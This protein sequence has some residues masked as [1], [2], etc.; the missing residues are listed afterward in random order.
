MMAVDVALDIK[1]GVYYCSQGLWLF[2]PMA[3]TIPALAGLACFAYKRWMWERDYDDDNYYNK[4]LDEAGRPKPGLLTLLRQV[5]Q[6]EFLTTAYQRYQNPELHQ[7]GWLIDQAFNG[8]LEGFPQCLLQT[9]VLLCLEQEA[10]H[11][12]SVDTGIQ[13]VSIAFSCYSMAKALGNISFTLLQIEP[14]LPVPSGLSGWQLLFLQVADVASR[15]LCWCTL[16][17]ALRN[18]SADIHENGQLVLPILMTVEFV[19]VACLLRASLDWT[20]LNASESA[21]IAVLSMT[22]AYLST[23]MLIFV[24]TFTDMLR[25]QAL[26]CCLRGF[27]VLVCLCIVWY[28]VHAV[29]Q[30]HT[31][32]L[33]FT[34][35]S[36]AAYFAVFVTVVFD[37][38]MR[39]QRGR[40]VLPS[41]HGGQFNEAHWACAFNNLE[42]LKS[43]GSDSLSEKTIEGWTP[44]H[45]AAENGHEAAL[46][47]VYVLAPETLSA[48]DNKGTV[49]A[50]WA[51][52]S[53]H[54][55]VLRLLNEIAPETLSAKDNEGHVP[56][57]AA[58]FHGQEGTLRL[59]DELAP[60]TLSA[61]DN[62]GRVLAHCAAAFGGEATLRFLH[63]IAP[64]TLSAKDNNGGVPAHVAARFGHGNTL[65]L[66]DELAPQTLSAKDNDGIV[67]A[68]EAA[69]E[70]DGATLELLY[71]L[72]PETFRD[73]G[74]APAAAEL[75]REATLKLLNEVAP[76]TMSARDDNGRTPAHEAA[77][78]GQE[79]TL[80]LLNDLAPEIMSARDDKGRTPAHEAACAGHEATLK[81]LNEVAPETMSARDDNGRTPA[82]EAAC[83]GQEATLKLLNDLAPETMSA[84]DDNGRTPAHYAYLV[85]HR[86]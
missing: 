43:C 7:R 86:Q 85:C 39:L 20:C 1:V 63:E 2:G 13:V 23:P 62:D 59:L 33:S 50:H 29:N 40:P 32:L 76:E 47:L 14:V 70:V 5:F 41:A 37:R 54:E 80:K 57:H 6:L 36:M 48:Q 44:A 75:G 72:A 16:G 24:A 84:R 49:P 73:A 19:A 26:L 8:V 18:P 51:A 53:G 81:L 4:N 17:A 82:H 9:Y 15:L 28:R 68:Y 66:L 60:E 65:R 35:G 21:A 79:A 31:L 77:C 52:V 34:I 3:L 11:T 78:A 71:E 74:I 46:H 38:F 27:E 67:P 55:A 22:V 12:D 61:K 10:V 69:F 58:A 56:A 45:L 42:L 64:E 25:V 83:A 30:P